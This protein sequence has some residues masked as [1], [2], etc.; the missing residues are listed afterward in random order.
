MI[1]PE[2]L[3]QQYFGHSAFREG[4]KQAV[5]AILQGRDVLAIMP[6]GAGKSVCYQISAL[7]LPGVTVVI[8]PLISLMKDQVEALHQAGIPAAYINSSISQEEYRQTLQG[9]AGGQYRILYVA[10]ERLMT[11]SFL[12]LS[13]HMQISMIAVDEAHCVSQWGQDFRQSYLSIAEF[14]ASLSERPICTAFT[15]T[16]TRQVEQDIAKLLQLQDPVLVKTGF[17]R[18]N[19]FFGVRKPNKKDKELLELVKGFAGKS[20]IVYCTTRKNVEEV[21]ETLCAAGYAATRYHAGLSDGERSRNQEDFLYDRKPL[22]V[23]TNAFGMGIDKSNV[24]F[25]IHYNMPKDLESYYQEAGRAG[26]DGEPAQCILLYSGRD[27]R[28]NTFLIEQGQE[29]MD[30]DD[31]EQRA[32]LLE[33]SKERLA[34]MTFYATSTTCLRHR[35][36][37]YFGD[38]APESC[39]N[40]SCCLG[41]YKEV[42]G[43]LDAKKIVSCVYRGQKAGYHLSRTLVADV[44]IGSKKEAVLRMRLDRLSTYGIMEKTSHKAVMQQIDE[45]IQEKNLALRPY[46]E[47]QELVLTVGS[48]EIIRGE[49]TIT[50][51]VPI[52]REKLAAPVGTPDASLSAEENQLF[53]SLRELR[54]KLA[55]DEGVPAYLVFTDASLRDMCKKKPDTMQAFHQVSGVGIIKAQKYGKQFLQEIAKFPETKTE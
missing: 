41:N 33:K 45:L 5:D 46:K 48:A 42:D 2:Q 10:P 49:K 12:W 39:G 50:R 6:T 51:R 7:L 15:A 54:A 36:L 34:Q 53:Q 35:M 21:C 4:Q 31:P 47:F 52:V 11:D 38:P 22:M 28:I 24:S 14:V 18:K 8:S 55:G 20:G 27:V 30:I 1:Q 43:T 25:V 32:F 3:L 9:A 23:A 29:N 44:L 26:R 17:D 40:C 16:A 19:L 37:R 13:Q